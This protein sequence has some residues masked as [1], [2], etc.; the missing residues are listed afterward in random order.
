MLNEIE[1]FSLVEFQDFI[2]IMA[3]QVVSSVQGYFGMPN[4]SAYAASKHALHGYFDSLRAEVAHAG[5]QVAWQ[6]FRHFAV[7]AVMGI[8]FGGIDFWRVPK[9]YRTAGAL[10]RYSGIGCPAAAGTVRQRYRTW[11]ATVFT[12]IGC[13]AG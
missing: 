10:E 5:V 3:R 4:R 1:L 9:Q 13:L 2:V 11:P 7:S 8:E 6:Y 12:G